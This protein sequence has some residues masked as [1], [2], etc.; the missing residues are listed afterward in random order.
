MSPYSE[1]ALSEEE[2]AAGL[3]LACRA[4][5]WSDCEVAYLEPDDVAAHPQRKLSCRVVGLDPMTHDIT[6]VRLAV[7]RGGPYS[8]SAGQ[9]ASVFFG[10]LPARNYSMANLP[11]DPVLEFHIRRIDG[12]V[13][14]P[15]VNTELR[16]GDT[17]T[18]EGPLG[19]SYLHATHKGPILAVAGGSGLA[20]IKSIVEQALQLELRQDIHLYFGVRDERDLYLEDHFNALASQ[21]PNLQFTPVLSQATGPTHRRTGFLADAIAEEFTDLDGTKVYLAGPPIMVDTCV[22]KVREL[23]VRDEDCHADAFYTEADRAKLEQVA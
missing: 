6:R 4:V 22:E 3:I 5:P 16:I 2:K 13:V 20:P 23:G 8:F 18:V 17:V 7:E 1:F 12:G 19:I 9:Y 15:F 11:N 21:H 14:S 10:D